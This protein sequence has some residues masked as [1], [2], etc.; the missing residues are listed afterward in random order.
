MPGMKA[1]LDYSVLDGYEVR[2]YWSCDDELYVAEIADLPGCAADGETR[3]EAIH[4]MAL[5]KEEWIQNAQDL[6]YS[7]PAPKYEPERVMA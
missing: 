6:G 7:I 2:S 1:E 4:N 3:E 5:W